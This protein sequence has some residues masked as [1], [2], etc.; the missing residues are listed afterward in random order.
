[1]IIP[2]KSLQFIPETFNR[3][4]RV[5]KNQSP[6][7]TRR[8]SSRIKWNYLRSKAV[9]DGW[10]GKKKEW[11]PRQINFYLADFTFNIRTASNYIF[12]PELLLFISNYLGTSAICSNHTPE[13]TPKRHT[14]WPQ[15]H[16]S[17]KSLWGFTCPPARLPGTRPTH[18]QINSIASNERGS[19]AIHPIPQLGRSGQPSV[20]V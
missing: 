17:P 20:S 13:R 2:V 6:R 7:I 15:F 4:T 14:P 10:A 1:M 11:Y 16:T 18:C 12:F 5:L 8:Q 19:V 9:K 3:I